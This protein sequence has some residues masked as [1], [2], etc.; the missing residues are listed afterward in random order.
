MNEIGQP[1]LLD[2]LKVSPNQVFIEEAGLSLHLLNVLHAHSLF[3]FF[4]DGVK[5]PIVGAEVLLERLK[6]DDFGSFDILGNSL[7]L[8]GCVRTQVSFDFKGVS[9]HYF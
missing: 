5:Q 1:D 4:E 6:L 3:F 8:I 9:I 2:F 7:R